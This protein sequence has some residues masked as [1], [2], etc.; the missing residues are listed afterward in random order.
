[1]QK[2]IANFKKVRI[3]VLHRNSFLKEIPEEELF[4]NVSIY[5]RIYCDTLLCY[6]IFTGTLGIEL[7]FLRV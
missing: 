5:I 2:S 4:S 7:T 6:K 3:T 1:M